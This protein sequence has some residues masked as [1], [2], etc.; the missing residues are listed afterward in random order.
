MS[1]L[2]KEQVSVMCAAMAIWAMC[3]VSD[4]I[5]AA[6]ATDSVTLVTSLAT[7]I[8]TCFLGNG[9]SDELFVTLQTEFWWIESTNGS[10][11]GVRGDVR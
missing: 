5:Q 1:N 6:L 11:V 9:P 8:A 7:V 2:C 3:V 4:S 10:V